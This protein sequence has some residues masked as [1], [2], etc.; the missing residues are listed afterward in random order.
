M[1]Y[2]SATAEIMKAALDFVR[3]MASDL[4][5]DFG[6]GIF[7][8]QPGELFQ[9]LAGLLV[10][11]VGGLDDDLDDLV[12]ALVGALVQHAPLAEAELLAVLG[13][14]RDL[15]ERPAVNGRRLDLGAESGLPDGDGQLD[16]DIVA[17]ALEER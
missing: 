14:A 17:F 4:G 12:A 16:L 6:S 10:A 9:Q 8:V 5:P 1:A 7:G 3:A 11:G 2:C 13:A 15:E